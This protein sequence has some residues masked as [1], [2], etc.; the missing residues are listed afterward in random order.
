MTIQDLE[1]QWTRTTLPAL[2][3]VWDSQSRIPTQREIQ[4]YARIYES[5]AWYTKQGNEDARCWVAKLKKQRVFWG[6]TNPRDRGF[7]HACRAAIEGRNEKLLNSWIARA[8]GHE[9]CEFHS[10]LCDIFLAHLCCAIAIIQADFFG[11]GSGIPLAD[12][13]EIAERTKQLLSFVADLYL[14]LAGRLDSEPNPPE[15]IRQASVL[16]LLIEKKDAQEKGVVADL[17]LEALAPFVETAETSVS[18]SSLGLLYPHP[19]LALVSRDEE[20]RNSEEQAA[21]LL[22]RLNLWPEAYR[23]RWN[24]KRKDAKPIGELTGPSMGLAFA[25]GAGQLLARLHTSMRAQEPNTGNTE[26]DEN[27]SASRRELPE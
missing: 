18:A 17:S 11:E 3:E 2:E 20:F 22:R 13:E 5:R 1:K 19:A 16:A 6:L 24:L 21:N 9:I 8:E 7:F 26:S 15:G 4:L 27:A 23:V 12:L 25:M 14:D 10:D